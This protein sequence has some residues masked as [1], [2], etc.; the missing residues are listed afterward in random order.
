MPSGRR[1]FGSRVAWG[2]DLWEPLAGA[3]ALFI[4]TEW[5]V[6]RQAPP[7]RVR[8]TMAGTWVFDGRGL[9]DRAAFARAGLTV[10]GL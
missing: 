6:F 10:V 9:C 5:D 4:A 3:D 7:E 2:H 1:V 8:T